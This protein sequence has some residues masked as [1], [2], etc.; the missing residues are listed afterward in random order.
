MYL[1]TLGI[2]L[3]LVLHNPEAQE[4]TP[5]ILIP[6]S[7]LRYLTFKQPGTKAVYTYPSF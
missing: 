1:L 4:P 7:Y 5:I 2:Y 6:T 3:Y